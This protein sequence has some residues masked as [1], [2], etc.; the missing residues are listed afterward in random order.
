MSTTSNADAANANEMVDTKTKKEYKINSIHRSG[1]VHF[2]TTDN[3][4]FS[5]DL[6]RLAEASSFFRN[7][8]EIPQSPEAGKKA[9]TTHISSQELRDQLVQLSTEEQEDI[10]KHIDAAITFPE[11][12]SQVLDPWLGL[13][14]FGG[15]DKGNLCKIS[16]T[17]PLEGCRQMYVLAYKYGCDEVVMENMRWQIVVREYRTM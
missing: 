8:G 17:I 14:V 1:N 12:G 5:C 4:L 6:D 7:L 13:L 10:A 9:T 11:C 16:T 3:V 2:I 15:T